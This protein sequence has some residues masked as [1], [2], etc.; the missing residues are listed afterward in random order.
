MK[1]RIK[2]I[3][4]IM[5]LTMILVMA[6]APIVAGAYVL[7]TSYSGSRQQSGN[8]YRSRTYTNGYLSGGNVWNNISAWMGDRNMRMG[9]ENK[10]GLGAQTIYS[11]YTVDYDAW[12][13][14]NCGASEGYVWKKN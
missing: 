1:T 13:Q 11:G 10:Y 4:M 2:R 12:H 14:V 6:I 8:I 7:P 5:T 3:V 9:Y